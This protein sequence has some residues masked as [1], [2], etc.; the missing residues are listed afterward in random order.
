MTEKNKASTAKVPAKK[1][2]AVSNPVPEPAESLK[3]TVAKYKLEPKEKKS[4]GIDMEDLS[5]VS[6]D[7]QLALFNAIKN[8][9]GLANDS[10]FMQYYESEQE[11]FAVK[12]EEVANL[13]VEGNVPA[14]DYLTF[15]YK[16]GKEDMF[17]VD[18]IRA[19]QWGLLAVDGGSKLST[20]RLR[21][22]FSPVYDYVENS[23]KADDVIDINELDEENVLPFIASKMAGLVLEELGISLLSMSR[24]PLISDGNDNVE[25][26]MR[27]LESAR[28]KC[29]EP[30]MSYLLM[31]K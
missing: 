21:L 18:L 26:F 10:Q 2:A 9:F 22:F 29:F 5:D 13:A 12:L 27:K 30:M 23:E 7:N 16:K 15:V 1:S 17:E 4:G 8:I 19:H 6:Y 28:N 31:E 14:M 24:L 3:P 25:E 20:E 11:Y